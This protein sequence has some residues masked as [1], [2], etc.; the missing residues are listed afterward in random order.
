MQHISY[1]SRHGKP[2]IEHISTNIRK[3]VICENLIPCEAI[4]DHDAP[5][6]VLNRK[7][8]KFQRRYKFAHDEKTFNSEN[9]INNLS[10]L[11]LFTVYSFND[12]DDQVETLN[13]LITDCL[14]RH[15]Q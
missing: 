7:K 12:P 8:Q 5:F 9:Y 14:S 11:L 4:S 15:A 6:V 2:L 13:K 1:P 10:Q 3:K